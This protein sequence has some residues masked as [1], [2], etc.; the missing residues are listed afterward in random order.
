MTV[1]ATSPRKSSMA[2][3]MVSVDRTVCQEDHGNVPECGS[4][5]VNVSEICEIVLKGAHRVMRA[6]GWLMGSEET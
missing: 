1:H 5:L 4:E 2:E 6:C 3:R